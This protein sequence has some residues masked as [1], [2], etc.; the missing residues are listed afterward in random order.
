MPNFQVGQ[1][2]TATFLSTM[3]LNGVKA[4][5]VDWLP[6]LLLLLMLFQ[7][8][9][10][11]LDSQWVG[12]WERKEAYILHTHVDLG[13]R[14]RLRL[15]FPSPNATNKNHQEQ[16]QQ[17]MHNIANIPKHLKNSYVVGIMLLIFC[18]CCRCFFSL[19]LLLLLLFRHCRTLSSSTFASTGLMLQV[20]RWVVLYCRPKKWLTD[21]WMN[22]QTNI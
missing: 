6:L 17:Q 18:E 16:Q 15:L 12:K 3:P 5:W 11:L 14:H 2:L 9:L 19:L 21:G 1:R 8:I 4:E 22:G 7:W 13:L 20:N 10:P